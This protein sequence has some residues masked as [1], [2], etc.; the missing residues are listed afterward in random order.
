MKRPT[1]ASLALAATLLAILVPAAG[2]PAALVPPGNSAVTQYTESLPTPGGHKDTDKG[3][4][5]RQRSPEEALGARNARQLE[6]QGPDGRAAAAAAAET[7]PTTVA[8]A[9]D[10]EEEAIRAP[11][12]GKGGGSGGSKAPAGN[13]AGA[14]GAGEAVQANV[15]IE[16]AGAS[17]GSGAAAGGGT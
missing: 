6:A 2:A 3:N 9:L 10:C 7:A 12:A 1:S 8:P 14:I 11:P 17:S 13:E 16:E 15:R 5:K 4:K